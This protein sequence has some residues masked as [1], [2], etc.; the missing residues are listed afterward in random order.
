MTHGLRLHPLQLT[1]AGERVDLVL[2]RRVQTV[3]PAKSLGHGAAHG[4]SA[5]VAQDGRAPVAH[6]AHDALALVEV[7]RRALVI[8]VA[9]HVPHQHRLLAERQ[10]SF[11]LHADRGNRPC[12]GV[13][14]AHQVGVMH[15]NRTVDHEACGV[16][17]AR[18]TLAHQFAVEIDLDQRRS[19]DLVEEHAEGIEQEMMLRPGY[20]RGNVCSGHVGHAIHVGQLVTGRQ[21]TAQLPFFRRHSRG[22]P[23]RDFP[24]GHI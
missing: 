9:Q 22:R 16:E 19:G 12:V 18:I 10:Q 2:A 11:L 23:A 15:V 1:V 24:L 8:V 4:Q 21:V 5:M 6:V 13:H 3:H 7:Q 20:A 14:D 17:L